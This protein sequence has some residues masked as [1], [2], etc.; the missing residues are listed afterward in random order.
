MLS[1]YGR[2]KCQQELIKG[3]GD[4]ILTV[5]HIERSSESMGRGIHT[6]PFGPH[7]EVSKRVW[8]NNI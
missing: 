6:N 5:K 7:G 3:V 2:P 4:A 8:Y 1:S